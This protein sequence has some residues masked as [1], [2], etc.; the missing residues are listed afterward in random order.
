[1]KT[2]LPVKYCSQLTYLHKRNS[3]SQSKLPSAGTG[4]TSCCRWLNSYQRA[5]MFQQK[6]SHPLLHNKTR[7]AWVVI[8]LH[9]VRS[10]LGFTFAVDVCVWNCPENSPET[11]TLP[12]VLTNK[13]TKHGDVRRIYNMNLIQGRKA[14]YFF[15]TDP[16]FLPKMLIPDPKDDENFDPWT[17]FCCKADPWF[18][19]K[20]CWSRSHPFWFQILGLWSL[21]LALFRPLIPDPIN[22]VTTLKIL[23]GKSKKF[24]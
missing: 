20:H 23:W 14:V 10:L 3:F 4:G 5:K 1:M 24:H 13:E 8:E 19:A 7:S 17:L 15:I 18:H 9:T 16:I 6:E 21:I 11:G 2:T 22:L 12:K